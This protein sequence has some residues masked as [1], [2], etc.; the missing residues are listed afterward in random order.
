MDSEVDVLAES[1]NLPESIKPSM[2]PAAGAAVQAVNQVGL[3]GFPVPDHCRKEQ[4]PPHTRGGGVYL[5]FMDV[6]I[7]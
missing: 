7:E 4:V 3:G 6:P 1:A 2:R 5:A